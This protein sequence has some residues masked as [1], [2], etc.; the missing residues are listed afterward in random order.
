[1]RKN[2]ALHASDGASSMRSS[3]T[4]R[5]YNELS[6]KE[7]DNLLNPLTEDEVKLALKYQKAEQ[8]LYDTSVR[9]LFPTL[10]CK[11]KH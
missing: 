5:I 11:R 2:K 8:P 4:V 3:K 10:C 6:Q 1:M 9:D 7:S